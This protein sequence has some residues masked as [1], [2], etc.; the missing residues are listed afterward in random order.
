MEYFGLFYGHLEQVYYDHLVY[1]HILWP[2][3]NFVIYFPP[4]LIFC[5][6]KNLATLSTRKHYFK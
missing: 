1:I 6:K 2:F 3:G 5:I 4:V